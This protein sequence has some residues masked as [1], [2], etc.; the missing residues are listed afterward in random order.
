VTVNFAVDRYTRCSIEPRR[1]PQITIA[2]TDL[3]REAAY[4]SLEALLAAKRHTLSL[5]AEI[6]RFF[7][8]RRVFT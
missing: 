3:R 7:A 8:R 5:A 4:D 2:S 6:I 1:G